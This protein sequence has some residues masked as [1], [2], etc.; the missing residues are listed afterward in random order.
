MNIT[1][2]CNEYPPAQHGGIGTFVQTIARALSMDGHDISVLGWGPDP[3]RYDDCRVNVTILQESRFRGLGRLRTRLRIARWLS[4]RAKAGKLDLVEVPDFQGPLL[5]PVWN[6]PVVVRLHLSQTAISRHAN[7]AVNRMTKQFE[8]RTLKMSSSWIAVSEFSLDLTMKTFNLRPQSSRVIFYP[9]QQE[10]EAEF[11]PDLPKQFVLYAGGTVSERKGACVLAHAAKKFLP[12]HPDVFLL[13]A[14]PLPATNSNVDEQ[15]LSVVGPE[16]ANRVKFLGRVSRAQLLGC[17]RRAR[18]FAYPSTL[19][20]FGLVTA[21]AM[22]QG[23]PVVVADCGPCPEFVTNMKSGLLVPPND[24]SAFGMAI[25]AVLENPVL[26]EK[27]GNLGRSVIQNRFSTERCV[28]DSL[29]FYEEI[30]SSSNRL[31]NQS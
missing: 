26:A 2:I 8:K 28:S 27:M 5:C 24:P 12:R 6:V 30:L 21:E 14:G 16:L 11:M 1:Y 31:T 9:V 29:S 3:I 17:M 20:T 4:D 22:L 25:D 18:V 19:E 23:C 7:Q 15:I 13:Y 10:P